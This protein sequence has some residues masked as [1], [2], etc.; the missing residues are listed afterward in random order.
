MT[1]FERIA[2]SAFFISTLTLS[3]FCAGYGFG[4]LLARSVG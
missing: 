3:V 4:M 2:Y 1:K